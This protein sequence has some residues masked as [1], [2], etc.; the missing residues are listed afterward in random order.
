MTQKTKIMLFTILVVALMFHG[1]T[2]AKS[3][4][5]RQY[6]LQDIP[7]GGEYVGD[8]IG[9]AAKIHFASARIEAEPGGPAATKPP[10]P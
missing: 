9:K 5:K 4:E 8:E 10:D 3:V 2:H 1:E 6:Y 7:E